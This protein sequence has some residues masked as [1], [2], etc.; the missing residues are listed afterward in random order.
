MNYIALIHRY[1]F[2]NRVPSKHRA[3]FPDVSPGMST[4]TACKGSLW[5]HAPEFNDFSA[6]DPRGPS[7]DEQHRIA[8]A[9][10]TGVGTI[11]TGGFFRT[12]GSSLKSEL[13]E[14]GRKAGVRPD[15]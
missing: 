11:E 6:V 7:G 8:I 14:Q 3:G 13:L 1:P 2:L 12:A 4:S 15:G 10:R 5:Y 9:D